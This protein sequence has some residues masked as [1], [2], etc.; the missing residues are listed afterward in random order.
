MGQGTRERIDGLAAQIAARLELEESLGSNFLVP[1]APVL[2]SPDLF[3]RSQGVPAATPVIAPERGFW[4]QEA[5]ASLVASSPAAE[6]G[7]VFMDV[8]SSCAAISLPAPNTSTSAKS[9]TVERGQRAP[10]LNGSAER[11]DKISAYCEQALACT[12]CDLCKHRRQVVFGDGCLDS[13]LVFIGDAPGREEDLCGEPFSGLAGEF[14]TAIIEK[15]LKRPRDSVF[16]TTAVK[17]RP[18]LGRSPRA[19]EYQACLP[20]LQEQIALIR[21]K[22]I[23][24]LGA[25]AANV[26]CG[27]N[28]RIEQIRGLWLEFMGIPLLPVYDIAHLY[29]YRRNLGRNNAYERQFWFDLLIVQRHL[30]SSGEGAS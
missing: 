29:R 10:L 27:G 3:T 22:A 5:G 24:A 25:A 30:A 19:A 4:G 8:P 23:V 18:E 14:F 13:D 1:A 2:H 11:L 21:P 16:L 6:G 17:C 12:R 26:L 28:E 9:E 15:G 7:S 20:Y